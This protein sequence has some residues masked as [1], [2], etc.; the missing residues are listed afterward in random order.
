MN[1]TRELDIIGRIQTLK[2]QEAP[3]LFK[4]LFALRRERHR[5]KL[6][7]DEY[8]ISRG[9]SQECKDLLQIFD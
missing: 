8:P 2:N 7:K 5:D 3:Q 1:Q 6:E 9:R 4:E